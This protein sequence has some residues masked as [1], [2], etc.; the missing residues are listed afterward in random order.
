MGTDTCHSPAGHGAETPPD[1]TLSDRAS[2]VLLIWPLLDGHD[3]P[4]QVTTASRGLGLSRL[5]AAR[6][7]GELVHTGRARA[8]LVTT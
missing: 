4:T 7:M 1:R 6:A 3:W 2:L 8:E 5:D